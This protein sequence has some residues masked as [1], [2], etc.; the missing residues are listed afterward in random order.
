MTAI[1]ATPNFLVI[2]IYIRSTKILENGAFD[3]KYDMGG[4]SMEDILL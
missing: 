3:V 1:I 4:D 2:H